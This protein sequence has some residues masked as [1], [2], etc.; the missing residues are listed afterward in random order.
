MTDTMVRRRVSKQ[1]T[2][3]DY[4]KGVTLFNKLSDKVV[5]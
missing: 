1:P 4:L 5:E 3:F 2:T